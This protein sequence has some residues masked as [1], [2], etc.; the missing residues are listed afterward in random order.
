[1][2]DFYLSNIEL[3]NSYKVIADINGEEHTLS[4]WQPYYIEGLPIGENTIKLSLVDGTGA[5]VNVPLNPVSRAFVLQ[6]DPAE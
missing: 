1:M 4:T 6:E 5:L 2:L 3:G